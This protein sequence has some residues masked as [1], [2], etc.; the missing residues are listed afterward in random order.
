MKLAIVITQKNPEQVFTAFRLANVGLAEGDTVSVFLTAEGVDL[1]AIGDARFDIRGQ[2]EQF[3]RAGGPILACGTCLKMRGS[4][5]SELCP[6]SAMKALYA[7][8]R[9]ADRTVTF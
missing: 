3:Q 4:A 7:L 1:E 8:I 9:E 5:G 2:A 6:A